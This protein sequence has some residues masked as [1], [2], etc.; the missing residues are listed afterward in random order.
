MLGVIAGHDQ[1]EEDQTGLFVGKGADLI[2]LGAKLPKEALEQ[3][4]RAHQVME[5][6]RKLVEGNTAKLTL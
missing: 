2:G 6:K 4:T 5:V 3:V 1:M